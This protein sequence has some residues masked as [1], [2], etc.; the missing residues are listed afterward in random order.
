MQ[1]STVGIYHDDWRTT[2]ARASS[3]ADLHRRAV[4]VKAGPRDSAYMRRLFAERW[5]DGQFVDADAGTDWTSLV[6]EADVVVLL[7]PDAIGLGFGGIESLVARNRKHWA[8]VRVLNGRRRSFVLSRT[9]HAGLRMRRAI[10]RSMMGEA[11]LIVPFV[12]VTPF[13]VAIDLLR[14]RR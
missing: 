1:K 11:L 5:P 3:L 7:Y 6:R 14:G 10:E 12:M 13:L 9:A 2:P 4:M 8:T